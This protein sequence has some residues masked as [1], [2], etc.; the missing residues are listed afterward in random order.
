MRMPSTSPEIDQIENE[1]WARYAEIE[2]KYCWVQTPAIQRLLRSGYV[3]EIARSLPARGRVVELGCGAGWLSVL[4]AKFTRA[5]IAGIDFSERQIELAKERAA[6]SGVSARLT[7]EV[8]DSTWLEN[9]RDR[10]SAAIMHGFLHHLST[11]EIRATLRR[12]HRVLTP[13]GRLLIFEPVIYSSPI[14]SRRGAALLRIQR[15][16]MAIARRGLFPSRFRR[17]ADEEARV[18]QLLATRFVGVPPFGPSPKEVPFE[19]GELPELLKG[20]FEVLSQKRC[21]ATSHLVAQENLLLELSHPKQ[22]ALMR[23][24]L[25]FLARWIDRLLIAQERPAD[26]WSCEL[27]DCRAI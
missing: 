10:F 20:T 3:K 21:M 17:Q 8:A 22:A 13:G 15:L 4:L 7:F 24:P 9:T 14:P 12:V 25:L 16:L 18:R 11:E 1:W 23:W 5:D 26:V 2:D 27:F 6:R 19:P